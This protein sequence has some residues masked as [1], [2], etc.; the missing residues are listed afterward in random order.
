[1]QHKKRTP[2]QRK[3]SATKKGRPVGTGTK[4]TAAVL[5]GICASLRIGVPAKFAAEKEGIHERTFYDWLAKG[6][7][8]TQPYRRLALA[9]MR[10]TAEGVCN[11][12]ARALAGGSGAAQAT[13]I[14][15]RRFRREYAQR[16]IGREAPADDGSLAEHLRLGAQVRGCPEA[17]RLMH[18]SLAAAVEFDRAKASSDD[19][20]A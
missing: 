9:A 6:E 5:E 18:E 20:E 8:G 7:K 14:L 16:T 2:R 1:M 3:K 15:E 19:S 11:L 17:S 10:A 13:W 12:T 4:L